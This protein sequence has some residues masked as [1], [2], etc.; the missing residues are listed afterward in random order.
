VALSNVQHIEVGYE[1]AF[2]R[3][4]GRFERV[5]WLLMLVAAVAACLGLLGRGHF[6]N[7]TVRSGDMQVQFENVARYKTPS[8]LKVKLAA[9]AAG[10][11]WLALSGGCLKKFSIDSMVP[12]PDRQVATSNGL[13]LHFLIQGHAR[14][15]QLG[16]NP[17]SSGHS[18][19]QLQSAG[20]APL[21]IQ[22]FIL[23]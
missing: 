20:S 15:I 9:T 11:N 10:D 19:C 17:Q 4:W 1:Y 21:T 23:P 3:S 5:V 13:A 18:T 8:F 22:Q 16:L 6:A 7:K 12:R 2:E 14:E